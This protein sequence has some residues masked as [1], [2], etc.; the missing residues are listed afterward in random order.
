MYVYV[1]MYV[2]TRVADE[3]LS[4]ETETRPRLTRDETETRRSLYEARPRRDRDVYING[5]DETETRR[6]FIASSITWDHT[7]CMC[8]NAL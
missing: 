3:T 7:R 4:A 8:S 6:L 1:C 5:R 2:C